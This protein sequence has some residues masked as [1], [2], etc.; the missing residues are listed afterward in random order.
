ALAFSTD[1]KTLA[2][3][4]AH[5]RV[6]VW[7]LAGKEARERTP[8]GGRLGRLREAMVSSDARSLISFSDWN[9]LVWD[10][11]G[12]AP[13][14]R[15]ELRDTTRGFPLCT[16]APN[17]KMLFTHSDPDMVSLWDMP[18]GNPEL[19]LRFKPGNHQLWGLRSSP[20][21]KTLACKCG[22]EEVRLWDVS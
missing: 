11:T 4:S 17:G 16:L 13:R 20:D 7:D 5:G 1:G 8:V 21:S 3:G 6:H 12:P 9:V 22:G 10:L 18:A 19:R 14:L 15:G 2:A